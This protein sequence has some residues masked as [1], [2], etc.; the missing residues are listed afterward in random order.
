MSKP[1][2][3]VG[4]QGRRD[5]IILKG[6]VDDGRRE[7]GSGGHGKKADDG[8]REKDDHLLAPKELPSGSDKE[9]EGFWNNPST[10]IGKIVEINY[11]A[12][13]EN[14]NGGKAVQFGS[15]QCIRHDKG[16]KDIRY[17][18]KD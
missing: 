11:Q 14:L 17:S 1:V 18:D 12:E 3:D 9:R 7:Q 6:L 4:F 10:I 15:F 5:R 16:I 2:V 13:S 8:R